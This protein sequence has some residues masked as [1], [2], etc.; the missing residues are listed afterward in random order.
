MVVRARV[1]FKSIKGNPLS[2]DRQRGDIR[3]DRLIEQIAV[4]AQI[5]GRMLQA[6]ESGLHGAY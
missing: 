1:Q 4:H 5:T 6:Y 2:S 3:P